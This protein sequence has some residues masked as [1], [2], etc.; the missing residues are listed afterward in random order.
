MILFPRFLLLPNEIKLHIIQTT[1]PEDIE[2]LALS[3]KTVHSLSEKTL[4]Q[5]RADKAKWS[6]PSFRNDFFDS[7]GE[8]PEELLKLRAIVTNKRL[9]HYPRQLSIYDRECLTATDPI[10]SFSV[11][12][13]VEREVAYACREIFENLSSP[14]M[15]DGGKAAWYHKLISAKGAV[16]P[17][18]NRT[19]TVNLFIL[20]FLPN[21]RK[22]TINHP[23]PLH[24]EIASMI[25]HISKTNHDAPLYMKDR[26]SLTK[27][28]SVEMDCM[29]G[30]A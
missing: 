12:L 23:Q 7:N 19:A 17:N 2:N 11:M 28:S 1:Y 5:H 13:G 15:T 9:H 29:S 27:L 10:I 21:V 20:A 3:C 24:S 30:T 16:L 6:H 14:Y 4:A 18:Q 25:R 8:C 22:I 26:L